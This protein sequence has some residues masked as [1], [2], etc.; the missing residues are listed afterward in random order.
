[1]YLDNCCGNADQKYT[2]YEIRFF[3]HN[4]VPYKCLFLAHWRWYATEN[5]IVVEIMVGLFVLRRSV[6]NN[7]W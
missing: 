6:T 4:A 7:D 5:K 1:M 3:V 2:F